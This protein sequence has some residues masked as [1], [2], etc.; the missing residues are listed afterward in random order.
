MKSPSCLLITVE[1]QFVFQVVT[2]IYCTR[3]LFKHSSIP[4]VAVFI[5]CHNVSSFTGQHG[6]IFLNNLGGLNMWISHNYYRIHDH[7]VVDLVGNQSIMPY[8]LEIQKICCIQKTSLPVAR[9]GHDD[10]DFWGLQ[11]HCFTHTCWLALLN[12]SMIPEQ[13]GIFDPEANK[14]LYQKRQDPTS[15]RPARKWFFS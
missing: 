6:N 11:N 1:L 2:V 7:P 8:N 3:L 9:P 14:N 4:F 15:E 12:T 10:N 13:Q 5:W